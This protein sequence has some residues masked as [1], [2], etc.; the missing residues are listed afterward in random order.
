MK[1]FRIAFYELIYFNLSSDFCQYKYQLKSGETVGNIFLFAGK[2]RG[3]FWRRMPVFYDSAVFGKMKYVVIIA[4]CRVPCVWPANFLLW[5]G[6][7][8][9]PC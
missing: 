6:Y 4:S 7:C 9:Y 1:Y 2:W 8:L 3:F 5:Y